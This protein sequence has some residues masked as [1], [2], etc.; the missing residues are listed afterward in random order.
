[1]SNKIQFYF[2]CVKSNNNFRRL[3]DVFENVCT[4][5]NSVNYSFFKLSI[6]NLYRRI[7]ICSWSLVYYSWDL[8]NI[9]QQQK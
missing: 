3:D 6:A 9:K 4:T 2:Y 1:M 7:C 8:I 5:Y